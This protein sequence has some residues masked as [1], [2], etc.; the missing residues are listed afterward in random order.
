MTKLNNLQLIASLISGQNP[1]ENE[2]GAKND[3]YYIL[4]TE[5]EKIESIE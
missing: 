2:Q 1:F 3:Y 5:E 4:E